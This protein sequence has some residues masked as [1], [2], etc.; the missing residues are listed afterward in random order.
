MASLHLALAAV[1]KEQ[2]PL[3]RERSKLADAGGNHARSA[4]AA[5]AAPS[6]LRLALAVGL[7]GMLVALA[8]A[9][10]VPD[11]VMELL[12]WRSNEAYLPSNA[13][14]VARG[15]SGIDTVPDFSFERCAWTLCDSLNSTSHVAH[16]CCTSCSS[17]VTDVARN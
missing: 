3:A 15:C 1:Q 6:T 9:V 5:P 2:L 11:S 16:G 10:L 4:A 8:A 17:K 13:T 7:T 14:D 12:P